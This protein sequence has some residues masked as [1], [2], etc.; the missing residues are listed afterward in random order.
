MPQENPRSFPLYDWFF[1]PETIGLTDHKEIIRKIL[2]SRGLLESKE[3]YH[4]PDMMAGI[5]PAVDRIARALK[6][7]EK[8]LIHGDYDVD[9]IVASVLMFRFLKSA[10]ANPLV[11]LPSR[12]D[13]GYGLALEAVEKASSDGISLI[14]TVDCGIG[15][16]ANI[17]IGK[18]RGIDFVI[19]DHH[20]VPQSLPDVTAIVHPGLKDGKYPFDSLC[21]TVVAYKLIQALAKELKI[22]INEKEYF[23]Y[24]CLSTVTDIMPLIDENRWFVRDG[25]EAIHQGFA[26]H[27]E[28]LARVSGF[29]LEQIGIREL[30]FHVGSRLN[31]PGRMQSPIL[32]A[33]FLME[34]DS[35]RM[36]KIAGQI[37]KL[38]HKRREIQ[39]RLASQ[40]VEKAHHEW[41]LH[42]LFDK[43][44]H[45]G[46]IGTASARVVDLTG[47]PALL[48]T[49]GSN[50]SWKGS[51]RAPEGI[52]L[53]ALLHEFSG[54]MDNF[55]GHRSACGLSIS[56][57]A[58]DGF[59]TG[60]IERVQ[61]EF[62][63]GFPIPGLDVAAALSEDS[64]S[65]PFAEDLKSLE[66]CGKGNPELLFEFGPLAVE[67]AEFVGGGNHLKL[68]FKGM[69]RKFSGILFKAG[70]VRIGQ[71]INKKVAVI[72]TP[73]L[74]KFNGKEKLELF[75]KDISPV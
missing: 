9:G 7:G 13:H 62:P 57:D 38:N 22:E 42:I 65:L 56:K 48:F 51:G 18:S 20:Q 28:L 16:H 70:G 44:W 4:S 35:K 49:K 37:E 15:D 64:I 17:E 31:A 11:F 53:Y 47:K 2:V 58:F 5:K 36:L 54:V 60:L 6:D 30:G 33:K 71:L 3:R 29:E 67:S 50:G 12:V 27:I 52:D 21:G 74:N 61:S 25:I 8:I 24:L 43:E 63:D 26:P 55:G 68:H 46:L 23:P 40:A 73:V 72:A 14:I 32:S 10:G 1:I 19:T 69:K 41:D 75:V 34:T 59:R 39:D 45:E 66:P